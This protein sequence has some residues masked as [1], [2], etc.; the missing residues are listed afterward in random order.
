[1]K[2][3]G[4]IYQ[5]AVATRAR[6]AGIE[7]VLDGTTGAARFAEVPESVRQ[8]FSKRAREAR[9]AARELAREKGADWDSLSGDQQVALIKA[10]ADETR[11]AKNKRS[12]ADDGQSDFSVWRAQAVAAGYRHRSVLRPDEIKPELGPGE[13][14]AKAYAA[15]QPLLERAFAQRAKLDGQE[16]RE[17]AARGLIAS[18]IGDRPGEDIAAV[19]DGYRR[20]G[21]R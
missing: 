5:A 18:G 21:I 11:Q 12:P 17:I 16:L 14:H 15:S 3:G 19:L 2:E 9:E 6:R 1:V 10:G 13:R 4:A 7:V 8:V 20:Q